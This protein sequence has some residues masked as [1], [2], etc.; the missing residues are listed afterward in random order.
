MN[1]SLVVRL[2]LLRVSLHMLGVTLKYRVWQN[3]SAEAAK[4]LPVSLFES[5]LHVVDDKPTLLFVSVPFQL[6][7]AQVSE[8][9]ARS[10]AGPFS[11]R[12]CL[13][14]SV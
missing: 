11:S 2:L 14:V 10:I 6:E 1:K 9:Y 3:P 5:E 12:A 13:P 8:S 4:D 7:T